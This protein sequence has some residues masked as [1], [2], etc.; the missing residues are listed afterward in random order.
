MRAEVDLA[1][2]LDALDPKT[3]HDLVIIGAEMTQRSKECDDKNSPI[4]LTQLIFGEY[5]FEQS[6]VFLE[7]LQVANGG[8]KQAMQRY[9]I[10]LIFVS[11][12]RTESVFCFPYFRMNAQAYEEATSKDRPDNF[13]E[14]YLYQYI[15]YE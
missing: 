6:T 7:Y 3:L 11:N 13:Y 4:I 15:Y 10:Q 12:D 2:F 9:S 5:R 14:C 1:A 8:L